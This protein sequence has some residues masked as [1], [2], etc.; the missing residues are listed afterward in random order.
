MSRPPDYALIGRVIAGKYE[1]S[2]YVGGGG[3]GAVYR[4]HQKSIDKDVA[5][6]VMH[7]EMAS[8]PKFAE[9]FQREA[10][11]ASRLDHVNSMRVMDFGQEPDGVLY[12]VMELLDGR[13]LLDVVRDDPPLSDDRIVGILSQ[14]LAAL[15]VAHG[16]GIVHRDLKPENVMILA[17]RSDDGDSIDLVKVC[18][19][20]IAKLADPRSDEK[21][22]RSKEKLTSQGMMIGTPEYMSPEQARG[23]PLDSRSDLYS[24]GVILFQLITGRIPFE[25]ETAFGIAL[26][27]VT[28]LVPKPSSINPQVSPAL[29]A[30]CLKALQKRREDR[31]L[32]A[33]E[34]R[35]E[36][37]NALSPSSRRS[38]ATDLKVA[39]TLVAGGPALEAANAQRTRMGVAE[40]MLTP[41]DA[42]GMPSVR[43]AAIAASKGTVAGT[44]S[45]I[46]G[47]ATGESPR[48]VSR[49]PW[50]LVVLALLGAGGVYLATRGSRASNAEVPVATNGSGPVAAPSI[51]GESTAVPSVPPQPSTIAVPSVVASIAPSTSTSPTV[52]AMIKPTSTFV[53]P[54]P[55]TVEAPEPT[56]TAAIVAS[57]AAPTVTAPPPASTTTPVATA[58]PT[59]PKPPPTAAPPTP[60]DLA[61]AS[62]GIGAITTTNGVTQTQMRKAVGPLPFLKCYR[63]ALKARGTAASGSATLSL[64]IDDTGHVTSAFLKGADFLP[65]MR[66]CI[67]GAARMAKVD[68]DTGEANATVTLLFSSK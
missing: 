6:K 66:G 35:A 3:M 34:M 39:E 58:A 62:I 41:Q 11:A 33:R 22:D 59:V 8:D 26:K 1:I 21:S 25:G 28:D 67:E 53:P 10:R 61:T 52:V 54:A 51:S 47:A 24:V 55:T 30:V 27:H 36:L 45:V 7:P 31:Y 50:A 63:D 48:V 57:T 23:D 2:E 19:F 42:A 40:T 65:A 32:T 16:M 12:I 38:P 5:L 29:E 46:V 18:D 13:S 68:V 4:A 56:I 20:G 49:L 43:P 15:A 44:S 17:A 9:R 37:R 64:S 14:V 60:V